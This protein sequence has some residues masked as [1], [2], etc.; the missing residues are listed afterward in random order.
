MLLTFIIPKS[1]PAKP[2]SKQIS[3]WL[4]TKS[5]GRPRDCENHPM[6]SSLTRFP[7]SSLEVL[8]ALGG[9]SIGA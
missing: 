6:R 2:P 4:P 1:I 8:H 5:L 7:R 9:D 3:N